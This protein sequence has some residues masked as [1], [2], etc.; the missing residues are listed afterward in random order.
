MRTMAQVL[1]F[2][3]TGVPWANVVVF[4]SHSLMN[5]RTIFDEI[6]KLGAMCIIGSSRNYD[7]QYAKGEIKSAD[8]L[9]KGYLG[10]IDGGAD[11]IEAD[12]AIE[13]GKALKPFQNNRS[14][15]KAQFFH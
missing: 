3:K 8:E 15:S 13:A 12:L 5:D 2:E 14:S 1:E 11:I 4:V 7:A 10:I 9:T 6:H